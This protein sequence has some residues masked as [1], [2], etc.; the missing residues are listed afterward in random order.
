MSIWLFI[1]DFS[2]NMIPE[3]ISS[4]SMSE[5]PST[6]KAERRKMEWPGE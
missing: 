6:E 2:A 3:T 5:S 4:N 1:N